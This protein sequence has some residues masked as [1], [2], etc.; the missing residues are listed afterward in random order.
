MSMATALHTVPGIPN[1]APMLRL[2]LASAITLS[3]ILVLVLGPS[4][5]KSH[6]T[7]MFGT[8]REPGDSALIAGHR[9]DRSAAPEN[10]LPALQGALDG[11]MVY[12]ETDIRLSADGV[13]VLIHDATVDRTTNGTGRV[14]KLTLAELQKL[15]A[16][17]WYAKAF[18]GLRIPTLESFLVLLAASNKKAMLELKGAWTEEALLAVNTLIE[19]QGLTRRVVL[20]SF[21][22]DTL[23]GLQT[24]V[25]DLPRMVIIR[26]L[27]EDPVALV[28]E[29]GAIGVVTSPP[30]V[31][32]DPTVIDRIHQG[33][34]GILLYTLNKKQSWRSALALGVDG[35][36]T[37]KPSALDA[38]LAATAPGT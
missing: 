9:G 2:I 37:D 11:T 19:S 12:V 35:I 38:W 5:N 14:S 8:L 26:D 31:E 10:T 20:A 1:A 22:T 16:G 29:F 34:F 7:S 3:F 21:N 27:P 13:P 30:S 24:V 33:G 4:A 25:P 15:D 6:A 23:T 17:S 32:A 28:R 18:A 36:I